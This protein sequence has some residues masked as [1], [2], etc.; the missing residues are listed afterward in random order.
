MVLY[1]DVYF[2]V[3]AAMDAF[4]LV[5]AAKFLRIKASPARIF[6]GAAIGGAWSVA[7]ILLDGKIPSALSA[8]LGALISAVI[9]AAAFG[10]S[11]DLRRFVSSWAMFVAAGALLGGFMTFVYTQLNALISGGGVETYD[12]GG[13]ERLVFTIAAVICALA[14]GVCARIVAARSGARGVRVS[15]TFGDAVVSFDALADSGNLLREPLSSR[16]VI[17]VSLAAADAIP[18]LASLAEGDAASIRGA[19]RNRVRVLPTARASYAAAGSPDGASR[20]AAATATAAARLAFIP[21]AVKINGA[22]RSAVILP[23]KTP[24][25]HY[26]GYD[27]CVPTSLL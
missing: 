17:V 14:S 8:T 23:E 3:N 6:G 10:I 11:R 9:V 1:A 20:S 26:G 15:F 24:K 22:E 2:L 7:A 5:I 18:E 12:S 16:P 13:T 19:L 21:D 4:S 25:G 27:G